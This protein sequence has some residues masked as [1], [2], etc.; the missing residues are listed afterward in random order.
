MDLKEQNRQY[1]LAQQLVKPY[2]NEP[3]LIDIDFGVKRTGNTRTGELAIRFK[4]REKKAL[5][6]MVPR[7][8]FP[9]TIRQFKTDVLEVGQELHNS[10]DYQR[11]KARPIAGGLQ[12]IG[13]NWLRS[14]KYATLGCVI[15]VDGFVLGITN[16]HV[17]YGNLHP[18]TVMRNFVGKKVVYQNDH[19]PSQNNQIGVCFHAF[20][21]LLDYATV[22]IYPEIDVDP[23][24]VDCVGTT[25][26]FRAVPTSRLEIGVTPMKKCGIATGVTY[27]VVDSRSLLRPP[28]VTIYE[29]KGSPAADG[30][31]SLPGD[32]GSVW[33]VHQETDVI[34]M[35]VLNRGSQGIRTAFGCSMFEI[36]NSILKM[37]QQ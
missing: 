1:R 18:D 19:S 36:K 21:K 6:S 17:L 28:M 7:D 4:V 24:I 8:V 23:F 13:Q 30:W 37:I 25:D 9:K 34:R 35:A 27:G 2:A 11:S 31:L 29:D 16:Y 22:L 12:I 20:D 32:S 10:L 33:I 15:L 3:D 5:K 14:R 26:P